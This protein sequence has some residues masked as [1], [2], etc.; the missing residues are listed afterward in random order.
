MASDAS[1]W[2]RE[3]GRGKYA[4]HER[5]RRFLVRSEPPTLHASR[6]IEDRYL[7]GTRLR[8]RHVRAREQSVYKLTQKV[9]IDELD[10]AAVFVT[11]IYLSADE[12][13]RLSTL[14][15]STVAKTRSVC[16][17]DT[18]RF[19]VDAF[20]GRLEGLRL[21]EVEVH[22][23]SERLAVPDWVGPEVTH[24]NRFSG[25]YLAAASED[26]VKALLRLERT[27]LEAE[28]EPR[29]PARRARA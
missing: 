26:E 21:A 4:R 11:N 27:H 17:T 14:A 12:Y 13:L 24:D 19:V 7:D 9:R 28:Q 8:L 1:D 6:R 15:G 25:G 23:L 5:E 16:P 29:P 3:P 22:D 2:R 20:H 10:P 18:H